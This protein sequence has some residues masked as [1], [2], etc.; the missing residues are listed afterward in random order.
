MFLDRIEWKEG[1]SNDILSGESLK[2]FAVIR[3]IIPEK[4]K[5]LEEVRGIVITDYQNYLDTMWI[6][7]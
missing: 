7:E 3:D 1:V 5:K 6:K 4:Q 2:A